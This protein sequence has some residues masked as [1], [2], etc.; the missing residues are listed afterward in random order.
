ME[1]LPEEHTMLYCE[2]VSPGDI[3]AVLPVLLANG[4]RPWRDFI[5]GC[6][7]FG[8]PQFESIIDAL[9]GAGANIEVDDDGGEAP[10]LVDVFRALQRMWI[11]QRA[12]DSMVMSLLKAGAAVSEDI[13]DCSARMGLNQ[14]TEVITRKLNRQENSNNL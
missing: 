12:L 9:A 10:L 2:N 5:L 14:A 11:L 1:S 3:H 6:L 4:W 7:R 13:R 8:S